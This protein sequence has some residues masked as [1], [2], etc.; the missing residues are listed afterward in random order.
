[1]K[2]LLYLSELRVHGLIG[3]IAMLVRKKSSILGRKGNERLKFVRSVAR[4]HFPQTDVSDLFVCSCLSNQ[5]NSGCNLCAIQSLIS[6]ISSSLFFAGASDGSLLGAY[7]RIPT[8]IQRLASFYI[9][10]ITFK[11]PINNNQEIIHGF[12]STLEKSINFVLTYCHM[13]PMFA[14][15]VGSNLELMKITANLT[16]SLQSGS[17]ATSVVSLPSP[18]SFFYSKSLEEA[19]RKI[20][21]KSIYMLEW[22]KII[23]RIVNQHTEHLD[24]P[25]VHFEAWR[26]RSCV[27]NSLFSQLQSKTFRMVFRVINSLKIDYVSTFTAT[28][29]ELYFAREE[30]N[31]KNK[32]YEILNPY[33]TKMKSLDIRD[34]HFA[35]RPSMHILLLASKVSPYFRSRKLLVETIKF[36][37]Q[38]TL[39]RMKNMSLNADILS[40]DV[41]FSKHKHIAKNIKDRIQCIGML[42]TTF[43][44]YRN[45]ATEECP[46]SAWKISTESLFTELNSY[47]SGCHEMLKVCR[48]CQAY[49]IRTCLPTQWKKSI[50]HNSE[51]KY[52]FEAFR[53]KL[54]FLTNDHVQWDIGNSNFLHEIKTFRETVSFIGESFY[55]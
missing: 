45:R 27:L 48:D 47:L 3:F 24:D 18:P 28:L 14:S 54:L 41:M 22:N 20:V 46:G 52:N 32:I 29:R 43:L 50:T 11:S 1:M 2:S 17:R 21:F 33:L 19:H 23:L 36:I 4:V 10:F 44:Y 55:T 51:L 7:Q 12:L 26:E 9:Y 34:L 49:S 38:L 6:G 15:D 42:K 16:I 53:Q 30:A 25:I 8:H 35:F 5:N 13:P 40:P 39:Q 31:E 37:C